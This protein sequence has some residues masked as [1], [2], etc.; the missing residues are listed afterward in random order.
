MKPK[1]NF[2]LRLSTLVVL[3]A[4]FGAIIASLLLAQNFKNLLTMWGDDVQMTVYLSSEMKESGLAELEDFLNHTGQVGLITRISKEKAFNDFKLQLASYAP[5]LGQDEE[6]LKLIP[7]SLQVRLAAAIAPQDQMRTLNELA[8]KLKSK[9]GVEDISYGQD[10]IEKYG[11]IVTTVERSIEALVCIILAAALLVMSNAIRASVQLR[12]DEISV[13]EMIGAT[14]AYIRKP[15]LKEGAVLGGAS[16]SMAM[17]FCYLAFVAT[18]DILV[19]KL[20]FLQL[21]HYLTFI[22]PL[23]VLSLILGG[24]GLGALGSYLCVRKINDGWSSRSKSEA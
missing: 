15:F 12:R 19:T 23:M 22:S 24:A 21:G 18:K 20:S 17:L 5:D 8:A 6:L 9:E 3:T 10:W 16:V 14:Y 4:C 7:A 1:K 11:A 13:L 2:I